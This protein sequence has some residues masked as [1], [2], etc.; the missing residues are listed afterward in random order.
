M[1]QV[2]AD[3]DGPAGPAVRSS[4]ALL[5][6]KGVRPVRC[7]GCCRDTLPR[8]EDGAPLCRHCSEVLADADSGALSPSTGPFS[9]WT[10]RWLRRRD[11]QHT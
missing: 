8:P 2:F 4:P 6:G 7:V 1:T 3:D 11:A 10:P 9:A 5:P